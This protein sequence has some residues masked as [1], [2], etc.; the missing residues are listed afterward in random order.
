MPIETD[1]SGSP[2]FNDFDPKDDYYRTLFKPSVAV[3]VRELN[4][5]QEMFATQ[6]ERFGDNIFRRGTIVDG[7]NFVFTNEQPYVKLLD[8]EVD[9]ITSVL[10]SLYEGK[11]V[12]NSNGVTA[13]VVSS[14]NGFEASSPDL[15]T[16]YV[17]YINSG[18]D[19]ET[20]TFLPG[21]RITITDPRE[22]I[23]SVNVNSGGSGFSVSD[24]VVFVSKVAVNVTSGVFAAGD[25]I[26]DPSIGG[27][28][29]LRI[30]EVDTNTLASQGHVLLTLRPRVDDLIS[31]VSNSSFWS[32]ETNMAVA[33]PSNTAI[34]V[35]QAI[36]GSGASATFTVSGSGQVSSL[37][38]LYRG[39]GYTYPPYATIK[40]IGNSFGINNLDLL[41]KNY[42]AQVQISSNPEAIGNGY[43]FGVGNG[44]IYQKGS[45]L[46]VSPQSVIVSKY[47]SLPNNVVVGFKTNETIVDSDI[48]TDLLDNALGT[49]NYTAPGADRLKLTPVLELLTKTEAASNTDFFPLVEWNDGNPYK[50][51]PV[52]QYSRIGD[53]IA[54]TNYETSGSF[55]IDQFQVVTETVANTE[56]EGNYFT[57]TVDPGLAYIN[58][59]RVQTVANYK[60]NTLKGLDTRIANN[61]ISLNY[62]NYIRVNEVGG[63]FL[64]KVGA[65]VALYDVPKGFLSN[66]SLVVAG[67]TTPQGTN[68][69]TAK[70]RSLVLETDR[71]G[72]P[73]SVYR[74]YLFD[75]SMNTG[76]NF[77]EVRSIH[78]DGVY[79]GIA[80]I[81]LDYDATTS[82]FYASL[83]DIKFDGLLFPSGV[84]S[85]KNSNN[86]IYAYRTIDITAATANNGTL[87]KDISSISDEYFESSGSLSISELRSLYVVPVANNLYMYGNL[88]GTVNINTTSTMMVGVGTNFYSDFNEGDYVYV[89]NGSFTEIKNIKSIINA[90]A[91]MV[92]SVFATANNGSNFKRIFPQNVPIPFGYRN[93]LTANVDINRKILTLNFKQ[94]NGTQITFEG[95]TSTNTALGYNVRREYV[96][97]S[98][99]TAN[100]NQF[101]KIRVANNTG[102]NTGPWSIGVPD[103][104]RLRNVYVA[105]TSTVNTA[106]PNITSSFYLDHN[107]TINHL[108]LGYLYTTP[109]SRLNLTDDDYLLVEFDYF[110]GEGSGYYDAVSYRR[111][112]EAAGIAETDSKPLGEL[113]EAAHSLE[114]PEVYTSDGQYYDLIHNLDFRPSVEPTTVPTM[115]PTTAPVNPPETVT[116]NQIDDKKFPVPDSSA[117]LT[118]E[119]YLGR[120]DTVYIG[121]NGNIFIQN[122]LP[123]VDPKKRFMND[124]PNH[125]M[126]LQV[127]TIP[128]YPTVAQIKSDNIQAILTNRMANEIYMNIRL[129]D[130][131]VQPSMTITDVQKAQPV[132]YDMEDIGN[133]DRR[134][135]DLEYYVSFSLLETSITNKVIPSSVNPALNRFKFGFMVDDFS[136]TIYTDFRNPQYSATIEVD[137]DVNEGYEGVINGGQSASIGLTNPVSTILN[138]S[139]NLQ[140]KA[141]NRMVPAKYIWSLDHEIIGSAM[142]NIPYIDEVI[143][144]QGYSTIERQIIVSS[145]TS[146][147]DLDFDTSDLTSNNNLVIDPNPCIPIFIQGQDGISLGNSYFSTHSTKNMSGSDINVFIQHANNPTGDMVVYFYSTGKNKIAIYLN[148][149]AN[150]LTAPMPLTADDISFLSTNRD[151]VNFREN[152]QPVVNNFSTPP[153][154]STITGYVKGWVKYVLPWFVNAIYRVEV[155]SA[156]GSKWK[157]LNVTPTNVSTPGSTII[158][159]SRCA[160]VTPPYGTYNGSLKIGEINNIYA[161]NLPDDIAKT[162]AKGLKAYCTG[163]KPNTLH[164]FF[165]NGQEYIKNI[166]IYE[167]YENKIITSSETSYSDPMIRPLVSDS[168]GKLYFT[169]LIYTLGLDT[170]IP[171]L[172]SVD[173]YMTF[174][175]IG[176]GSYAKYIVKARNN[177][178]I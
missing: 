141:S 137:G 18:D 102:G 27:V 80:D 127:I 17:N 91:L 167:E 64:Y 7:C 107:Q 101:V 68:I 90:T 133:L 97:S 41:P 12:K 40:S 118:I 155:I 144:D 35:V 124:T 145:N 2:H 34:G 87:R 74:A 81:V 169:A 131:T 92:D 122:G 128:P 14:V 177:T 23:Y 168:Q 6:I 86:T 63:A 77:K 154:I 99:K 108:K 31:A 94:A 11:F 112:A 125:S 16:I 36:Y 100:R 105:N 170:Q 30:I 66:N 49:R 171:S 95:T 29:N 52:T 50:Q 143:I 60:I 160:L 139:V 93:G 104:F 156:D 98:V 115:D 56:L 55:A 54:K 84:E 82:Q 173:G 121:E 151:I 140:A 67:N 39:K 79:D 37:N 57:V 157:Y 44:V 142:A 45:F 26:V 43:I 161:G 72:Q 148:N 83:K 51:N 9:G 150:T 13:F 166:P 162:N 65:N 24:Q 172:D 22:V 61:V 85:L 113:T 165:I 53:Q 59:Q 130:H 174:E 32:L 38:M 119:Q 15:K 116:F 76:K 33:N 28:A 152:E 73:N 21:D 3:Q 106:S 126:K 58:G 19:G 10:P 47:D 147:N 70:I 88:T 134:I 42:I 149:D 176:K 164:K 8:T 78:Y 25:H 103:A 175:I 111:T 132:V 138:G 20:S 69:G 146:N 75:I 71:P 158:D 48:D 1:L 163:L 153:I 136:T 46:R 62:G 135:K 123:D 178:I 120:L 129:K 5:I 96:T 159:V 117:S 109:T 89:S 4:G 110:T 114:I